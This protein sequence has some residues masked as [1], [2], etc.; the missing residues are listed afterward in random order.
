MRLTNK[1]KITIGLQNIIAATIRKSP[2]S[3]IEH[4]EILL[5]NTHQF[6]INAIKMEST[7]PK[8]EQNQ[9]ELMK[10]FEVIANQYTDQVTE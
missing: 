8:S 1:F 6:L 5:L 2:D 10:T 9:L 7:Y 3:L 4:L